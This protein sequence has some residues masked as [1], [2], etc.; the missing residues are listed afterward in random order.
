MRLSVDLSDSQMRRLEETAGRFDVT[1]EVLASAA[2]E[3][4]VGTP[5]KDLARVAG[6]VVVKNSDLIRRL[7]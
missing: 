1:L 4:V 7:A 5:E 6:R 2:L 3:E